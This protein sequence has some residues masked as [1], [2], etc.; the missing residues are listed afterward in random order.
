MGDINVNVLK[1]FDDVE[2]NF[3]R[4]VELELENVQ[5]YYNLCVVYVERGDLIRVEKCFIKVG[6]S[7]QRLSFDLKCQSYFN[8]LKI[9]DLFLII[10]ILLLQ[11]YQM[12]FI[13]QY[14]IN[15]LNIVRIKFNQLI[16]K[17]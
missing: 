9:I 15:Y 5:V 6:D 16:K 3:V 10:Q 8:S 17:R 11:V 1:K 14:I 2:K 7:L 12:V 13:E 4:V